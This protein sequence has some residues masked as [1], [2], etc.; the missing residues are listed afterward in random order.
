MQVEG[1]ACEAKDFL[2]WQWNVLVLGY[3]CV[4]Y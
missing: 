4:E 3:H 1:S 2:G